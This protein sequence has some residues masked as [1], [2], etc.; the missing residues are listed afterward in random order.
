MRDLSRPIACTLLSLALSACAA[1][2]EPTA[3]IEAP[4]SSQVMYLGLARNWAPRIHQD[5]DSTNYKADYITK[6]NFDG[7]YAGMNNWNNLDNYTT[8]PAYVYFAVSET[9]THWFIHYAF[10]HPRDWDD[11]IIFKD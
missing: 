4:L 2:P 11:G 7:D 8:V 10:F 5:T 3:V 1:D 6:F 9:L